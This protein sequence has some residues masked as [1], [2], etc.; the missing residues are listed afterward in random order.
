MLLTQQ[1]E[2]VIR[3]ELALAETA[4]QLPQISSPTSFIVGSQE[5][6]GPRIFRYI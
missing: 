5:S 4:G 1:Q 3:L 6:W 2:A